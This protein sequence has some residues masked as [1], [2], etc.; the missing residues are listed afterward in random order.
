MLKKE[1][2]AKRRGKE[3]SVGGI[4]AIVCHPGAPRGTIQPANRAA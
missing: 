1:R 2:R 4:G 3:K